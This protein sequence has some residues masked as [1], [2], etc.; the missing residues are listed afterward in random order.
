[1]KTPEI[2]TVLPEKAR[3]ALA[4]AARVKNTPA[5]PNRRTKAIER[6]TR[7]AQLFNPHLYK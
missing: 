3:L 1:M 5:D 2:A 7:N 4:K 6:A